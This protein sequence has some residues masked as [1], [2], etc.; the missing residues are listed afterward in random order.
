MVSGYAYSIGT[1]QV[2]VD[3][4]MHKLPV[5]NNYNY[6]NLILLLKFKFINCLNCFLVSF[7]GTHGIKPGV[8]KDTWEYKSKI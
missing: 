8:I 2:Y 6:P 3:F 7:I 4:I 1:N 5:F